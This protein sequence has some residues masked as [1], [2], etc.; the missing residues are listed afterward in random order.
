MMAACPTKKLMKE[1]HEVTR[2]LKS[3]VILNN[4]TTTKT[5]TKAT[6]FT[7]TLTITEIT[8]AV[9][10]PVL[11]PA[12]EVVAAIHKIHRDMGDMAHKLSL[13][14][15]TV[16]GNITDDSPNTHMPTKSTQGHITEQTMK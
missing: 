4:N 3:A 13:T 14:M 6:E 5:K 9:S 11:E 2:W 16:S 15:A 1:D 7:M 8:I 12:A 10:G